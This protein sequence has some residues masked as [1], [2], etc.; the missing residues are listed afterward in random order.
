MG[1]AFEMALVALRLADRGDLANEVVAH[2][3]INLAKAGE[4]DLERL[5][6]GARALFRF[7]TSSNLVGCSTGR[8]LGL[9]PLRI[10]STYVAA[11]RQLSR[12]SGPYDM[13]PPA[14]TK[15]RSS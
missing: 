12:T 6:E 5:C 14:S 7:I 13:S 15:T 4:R 9:A 11:R 1:L 8:S 2:K 10:L 3:I